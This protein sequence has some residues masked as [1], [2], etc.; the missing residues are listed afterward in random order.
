MKLK[1]QQ[2]TAVLRCGCVHA[3]LTVVSTVWHRV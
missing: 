2:M 1:L 3:H